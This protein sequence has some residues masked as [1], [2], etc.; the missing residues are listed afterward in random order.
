MEFELN[1]F[2]DTILGN[3]MSKE[4]IEKVKEYIKNDMKS[5]DINYDTTKVACQVFDSQKIMT[6]E[7]RFQ[8]RVIKMEKLFL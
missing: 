1:E 4:G 5:N 3:L 6:Q 7:L 8:V 2:L